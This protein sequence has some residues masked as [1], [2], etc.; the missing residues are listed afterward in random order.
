MS[1][2]WKLAFKSKT[3]FLRNFAQIYIFRLKKVFFQDLVSQ[4]DFINMGYMFGMLVGS[5][6]FG[7]ISDKIGRKKALLISGILS[8]GA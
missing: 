2:S 6:L 5:F 4:S 7:I 8:A 1:R 3:I